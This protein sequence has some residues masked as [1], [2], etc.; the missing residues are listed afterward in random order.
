MIPENEAA[1]E[2]TRWHL[3]GIL[4]GAMQ[5]PKVEIQLRLEILTNG[6]VEPS[7]PHACKET[8]I[9]LLIERTQ[10]GDVEANEQLRVAAMM[11]LETGNPLPFALSRYLIG[12]LRKGLPL[13]HKLANRGR[14]LQVCFCIKLLVEEGFLPTRNLASRGSDTESAC[15]V[16]RAALEKMGI[17][18]SE[19]A[20]EKIW[21]KSRGLLGTLLPSTPSGK[22]KPRSLEEWRGRQLEEL[23]ST[24]IERDGDVMLTQLGR[25]RDANGRWSEDDIATLYA[26][27]QRRARWTGPGWSI[28]I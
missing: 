27:C 1:I 11:L 16:V 5:D 10:N 25:R 15:S 2:F 18:M 8:M 17:V 9:E 28:V 24:V 6:L 14:D 21:K 20:I 7:Y 4:P 22:T 3:R 23:I 12:I 26:E 19:D 13:K